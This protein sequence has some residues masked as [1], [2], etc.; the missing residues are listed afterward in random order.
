MEN[1]TYCVS[2][3][4]GQVSDVFYY[5][6]ISLTCVASKVMERIVVDEIFTC[7]EKLNIIGR[8]Q[9][10][11]FLKGLFT[12]TKLLESMNDWTSSLQNN[13]AM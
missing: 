2:I 9:Q 7:F 1:T 3:Q 10:G 11:F 8:T 6:P 13:N 12:R 4:K 5:R